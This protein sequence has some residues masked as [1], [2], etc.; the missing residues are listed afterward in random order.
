MPTEAGSVLFITVSVGRSASLEQA[1]QL[2][3]EL[4][5]ELREEVPTIADVVVH[6][7]P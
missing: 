4:E 1:H 6:T 3:S 2:A 7:E 5:E